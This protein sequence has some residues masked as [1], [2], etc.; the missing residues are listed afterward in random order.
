MISTFNSKARVETRVLLSTI[1]PLPTNY[2][3]KKESFLD[4]SHF[5]YLLITNLIWF[6]SLL[7]DI[8][9]SSLL[10]G[11]SSQSCYIKSW[12]NSRD[13][14]KKSLNVPKR[15]TRHKNNFEFMQ[16]GFFAIS[17]S[18][19]CVC[20]GVDHSINHRLPM[21]RCAELCLCNQKPIICP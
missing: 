10:R 16:I 13:T 6:L 3:I 20:F 9:W 14:W 11:H 4:K 15:W 21:K 12:K 18:W 1:L 2:L 19:T 5:F 17:V 8:T 7:D